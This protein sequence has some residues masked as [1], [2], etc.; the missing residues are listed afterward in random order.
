M[1][2]QVGKWGNSLGIRLPKHITEQL[3]LNSQ[4]KLICK[5]EQGR[6]ILEP[7]Q[8]PKYK[9]EDLLANVEETSEEISWGSP[10]GE[11]AW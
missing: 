6:L 4:D 1:E 5:V 9:L 11:E 2:L 3:D 7:I 8:K 10:Q